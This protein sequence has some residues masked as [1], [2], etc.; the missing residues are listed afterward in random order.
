MA[1]GDP[2]RLYVTMK[3]TPDLLELHR[4]RAFDVLA[5]FTVTLL[6]PA[7]SPDR[8]PKG[9]MSP[10]VGRV[11]AIAT[12]SLDWRDALLPSREDEA[13]D[14]AVA[15]TPI[16]PASLIITYHAA[17]ADIG[18]AFLDAINARR[19]QPLDATGN[20]FLA[21]GFDPGGAVYDHWCPGVGTSAIFGHR[22]HARPIVRADALASAGFRGQRVNVVIID[23]GLDK[24][25]IP[26]G[27]WGGG[28]DHYLDNE[29]V[30]KAGEAP[31]NSHGMMIA[32]S[33]L[34]LAP[35]TKLY[36]VPVI[37]AARPPAIPVFVSNVQ[38]AY[39]ALLQVIQTRRPLPTWSGPWVLVNAWG[40][41]DTSTDPTGS[42]TRNTEPGGHPMINMV[43]QAIEQDQLD[44]V[45]AAG[46]C[47]TFCPDQQ[48]GRLDRGPGHSIWGANAHPLVL[49]VSGVRSDETWVGYASQGPGPELLA[50]QKPDLCAPTQFCETYD[51]AMLSSGT[52]AA[53]AMAAGVVAALRSNPGWDQVTV[54]P[55]A[56]K[57]ALLAAARRGSGVS[58]WDNRLGFGI[59]DAAAAIAGLP[60]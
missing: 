39:T 14:A 4:N 48:C 9:D 15:A 47:G 11:N 43:T 18:R 3:T 29:L 31:P 12:P 36:D 44:I 35:E 22:G 52:S 27:N 33:I 51:A 30:L 58:G 37:P 59:I 53:C 6:A 41:F 10:F 55:Q 42:Y 23:E 19:N 13:Q 24:T 5:R 45:F 7:G 60:G 40:I 50:V 38:A 56:L 8:D 54:T 20:T 25:Q 32:R 26:P 17:S 21:A 49:S 28:L 16:V 34:D 2:V 46:N 57:A 1:Q